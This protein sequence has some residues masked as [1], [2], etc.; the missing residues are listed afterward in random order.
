MQLSGA[1]PSPVS[2]TASRI[3]GGEVQID[4]AEAP[5]RGRAA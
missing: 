3:G 1:V 2:Y 4:G 5:V